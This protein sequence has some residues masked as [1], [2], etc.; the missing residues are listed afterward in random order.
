ME[1][2]HSDLPQPL[3]DK[4]EKPKRRDYYYTLVLQKSISEPNIEELHHVIETYRYPLSASLKTNPIM[5]TLSD[6]EVPISFKNTLSTLI[7]NTL[8]LILVYLANF[9][10]RNLSLH[11][12]KEKNNTHLTNA[13]GVGNTLLNVVGLAVFI[14]LNIGLISCSSQAYG[15]K[16]Y[17]LVGFYLHRGLI[18][19]TIALIP[20]CCIFYWSDK[21]CIFMG[22]DPDTAYYIQKLTF[23]CI[24]GVFAMMIFNTLSAY[25]YSCDIFLPSSIAL[26]FSA[27]VFGILTYVL[28]EKT[29]LDVLAVSISFNVMQVLSALIIFLYIL[30]RKPV[31]GSFFWP[32]GPSFRDLWALFKHEFF[33]GSMMFLEWISLEIVYLFAGRLSITE[34]GAMTIVF[35]N[36]QTLYAVP[37]S[38]ADTVLAFVGNA[39]GEGN[40]A[41]AKSF[42]KA[43]LVWSIASLVCIE[44]AYLFLS[45]QIAEFYSSDPATIDETVRIFKIYL[46][47]F[48]PDFIQIILS[49][50]LRAIGKEKLGSVMFIVCYYLISLPLTYFLCFGV[51]LRDSGLVYGPIVSLYILLIWL[52][53]AY[54]RIDWDAQ[55]R[56]IES[57]IK[58]DQK[59]IAQD[60]SPALS[61]EGTRVLHLPDDAVL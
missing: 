28:F 12:A 26:I 51:G 50:G 36:F 49:S 10:V 58:K 43:G 15:A 13:I 52:I 16:K 11:F 23:N 42:L 4:P 32:K 61:G 29:D 34:L 3:L 38:L 27:I 56:E 47:Y 48:P 45:R 30:I 46:F 55:L 60:P 19:N 33:V 5:P 22:V 14:S 18:I 8:P 35:T 2:A 25:L 20:G 1:R 40:L 37:V 7:L 44:L 21:I 24:L 31:P 6:P 39:M 41:K 59:S 17:R 57:R 9:S 54:W 53:F